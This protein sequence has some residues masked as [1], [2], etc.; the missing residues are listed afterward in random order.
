MDAENG[1]D[2]TLENE[3]LETPWHDGRTN[4]LGHELRECSAKS[5][6]NHD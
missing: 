1:L 3:S 4:A 2:G 6:G 5:A